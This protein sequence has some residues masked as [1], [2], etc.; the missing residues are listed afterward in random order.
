MVK[1]LIK[2]YKAIPGK[3]FAYNSR[4]NTITYNPKEL[5]TPRGVIAL[6]HE[7]AHYKL[8]HFSYQ[9]DSELIQMEEE[10][11]AETRKEAKKFDIPIDESHI[12]YCLSTYHEWAQK[13]ATCPA[14]N[15]TFGEQRNSVLFACPECRAKWEVNRRKDRRVMR[16]LIK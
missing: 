9:Y 8:G 10:A 14:C 11:W 15:F 1:D 7:I 13:R 4:T 12:S 5:K 16:R 2:E 6:L 3:R